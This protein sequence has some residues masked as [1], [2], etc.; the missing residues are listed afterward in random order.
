MSCAHVSGIFVKHIAS[1][2][3]GY[4]LACSLSFRRL[5]KTLAYVYSGY[6]TM[7]LPIFHH[8][9]ISANLPI[10]KVYTLSSLTIVFTAF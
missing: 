9:I 7:V 4:A 6:Q 8:M 1:C 3:D 5:N 10:I 2:P